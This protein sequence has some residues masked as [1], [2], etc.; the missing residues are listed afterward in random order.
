M[1]EALK[2]ASSPAPFGSIAT[3]RRHLFLSRRLPSQFL[4]SALAISM[5]CLATLGTRVALAQPSDEIADYLIRVDVTR[6]SSVTTALTNEYGPRDP[7]HLSPHIDDQCNH[8]SMLFAENNLDRATTYVEGL[9]AAMGYATEM[10][11]I[12]LE[13]PHSGLIAQNVMATKIGQ[14]EPDSFTEIGAHIDTVPDSPGAGDNAAAV[15]AVVEMARVLRSYPSRYS[16]RFIAF[17]GEEIGQTGSR[18]HLDAAIARGDDI[19]AGLVMDGIGWSEIA[20][21]AMNCLWQVGSESLRIA[22]L[23]DEVRTLY[24]IDIQFRLCSPVTNQTSDSSS[25]WNRNIPAVLS[26]GG[27]PYVAPGYHNCGDTLAQVD[28]QNV[29]RTT[30]QNLAVLMELDAE[31]TWV[32]TDWAGGGGQTIWDDL[33]RYHS[34]GGIDDLSPG[35]LKLAVL[36]GGEVLFEDDFS[37]PPGPRA[38]RPVAPAYGKLG[39]R[40][41]RRG[42]PGAANGT[43]SRVSRRGLGGLLG[44]SAASIPGRRLRRVLEWTPGY[45]T[46]KPVR[47]LRLPG[48]VARWIEYLSAH[49]PEQLDKLDLAADFARESSERRHGL[50]H[51]QDGPERQSHSRLL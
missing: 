40:G 2:R 7:E 35:E 26:I 24:G 20:P 12:A 43:L 1:A 28:L 36:Q 50:A 32:Q 16:I 25:Y 41:R 39:N 9:F 45:R 21:E 22:A 37:R 11:P 38:A 42:E 34:A 18:Q 29:Y 30:L 19:R 14:L 47:R 46:G 31:A 51:T 4:I 48:R 13:G 5:C 6:L 8:D 27:L 33:A 23:F 10:E 3:A 15:A 17:V 44:R 49:R